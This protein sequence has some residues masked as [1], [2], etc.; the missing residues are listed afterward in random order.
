MHNIGK[1]MVYPSHGLGEI[2]AIEE[3]KMM[4]IKQKFYVLNITE[5]GTRIIIPCANADKVGLREVIQADE[6][7]K[8]VKILKTKPTNILPNWNKR[9]RESMDRIKSGSIYE[10]AAVF[11]NLSILSRGKELSFGENAPDARGHGDG[12]VLGIAPGGKGVRR[13]LRKHVDARHRQTRSLRQ[14]LDEMIQLGIFVRADL[15]GPVHGDDHPIAEPIAEKVH[16]AGKDQGQNRA[17]PSTYQ[18]ARPNK[19]SGQSRQ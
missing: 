1:T 15:F 18:I 3:K 11:R 4:G 6:V 19:Q 2:V 8:I 7:R 13:F 10:V 17:L 12:R 14:L 5:K 16:A 9:Y